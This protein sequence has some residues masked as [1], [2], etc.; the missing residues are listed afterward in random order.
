MPYLE[1]LYMFRETPCMISTISKRDGNNMIS[2]LH[3]NK[4]LRSGKL[5]Y[6][7]ALKVETMELV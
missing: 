6:L 2:T 4:G 5:T 1:S 3:L 7:T